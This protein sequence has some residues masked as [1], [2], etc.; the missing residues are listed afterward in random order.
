M[1]DGQT[2]KWMDRISTCRLD[3]FHW[4]GSSKNPDLKR[5]DLLGAGRV[6]KRLPGTYFQFFFQGVYRMLQLAQ[7]VEACQDDLWQLFAVKMGI[8]RFCLNWLN[9]A[10]KNKFHSACLSAGDITAMSFLIKMMILCRPSSAYAVL[11]LSYPRWYTNNLY[12]A[13]ADSWLRCEGG[14]VALSVG[15]PAM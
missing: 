7:G 2:N 4:K 5:H 15:S 11:C 14:A 1:T 8:W 3:P 10:W 13:V 6:S 12:K 9:M